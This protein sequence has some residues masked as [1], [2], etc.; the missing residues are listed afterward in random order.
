MAVTSTGQERSI[1]RQLTVPEL[2]EALRVPGDQD[3]EILGRLLGTASLIVDYNAPLAPGDVRD[4]AIIRIA[5]YLYDQPA[6]STQP[7]NAYRN[8]GAES[9]LRRYVWRSG[10]VA[11]SGCY[12][13]R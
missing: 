8:S 9:L 3:E 12:G 2:R 6:F 13:G 5:A 1:N 11:G 7:A 4:E 10:L